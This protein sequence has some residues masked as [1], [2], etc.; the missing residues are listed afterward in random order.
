MGYN[1]DIR[2][3]TKN[4]HYSDNWN[5]GLHF[6]SPLNYLDK[7]LIINLKHREDRKDEMLQEL[8]KF[9]IEKDKIIFIEAVYNKEDGALGCTAS[10]IKCMEY[11]LNNNLDNVLIL[12]DDY[13]FCKNIN[14][15]N[16]ELTKFLTSNVNWDVLLLNISEHGPPLNIKTDLNI[17]H[18]NLWSHSVAIL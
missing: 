10:H 3:F 14:L 16:I 15:F 6:Y 2:S 7:I 11:A 5:K 17:V 12:E 18:I 13:D 8:N 4:T 1:E 9:Q